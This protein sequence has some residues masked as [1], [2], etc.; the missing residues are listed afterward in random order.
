[1]KT[2]LLYLFAGIIIVGM[3]LFVTWLFKRPCEQWE[4]PA[5][6]PVL[7]V[8]KGGCDG[9]NWVELVDIKADTIRF[10]IYHDW[11]GNLLLD[12]DFVSENCNDL[13]LTKENW[14]EYITYFDGTKIYTKI[15]SDSSYCRLVPVFPAYYEEKIK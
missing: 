1:M 3:V 2:K 11:N 5:N 12:A 13:Q 7:A 14:N 6:V 4:K 9:G 8:W 15:Q 10:R